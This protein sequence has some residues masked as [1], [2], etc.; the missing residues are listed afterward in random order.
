MKMSSVSSSSLKGKTLVSI[1]EAI[2]AHSDDNV[3]FV[4]G[5]WF[6]KDRNG[7]EEYEQGPRIQGALFFDIDDICAKGKQLNPK[8]L[9]H[10]MPPPKLFAAAMDEMKITNDNHLIMYASEGCMMIHRAWFQIRN[11]GHDATKIHLLD[12]GFHDWRKAGGPIEEGRMTVFR[13]DD[14]DLSKATKYKAAERPINIIDMGEM[15]KIIEGKD[16]DAKDYIVVDVRA[17]ERF[18]GQ[19]EEPR[20]G[21]RLGHMPG[22][23]NLPFASLLNPENPTQFKPKE[24]LVRLVEG[25]GFSVSTDKKIL[26]SCGSGASACTLVA[27]LEVC[28]RDVSQNFVYDGSWSEWGAEAETP[29]VEDDGAMEN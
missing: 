2:E 25:A 27:A 29:I 17:K 11:S 16:D 7:R 23:L 28:G 13:A 26:A 6:L 8:G 15:L 24:D 3:K 10:M 9:P 1:Q 20:P 19:V 4:D 22:A 12:G 5:S 21:L 18:L 14:L